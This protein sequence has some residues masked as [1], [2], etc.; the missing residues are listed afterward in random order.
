MRRILLGIA[1]TTMLLGTSNAW[2]EDAAAV[3]RRIVSLNLCA[4]ELVSRLA[5]RAS[6]ASVTWLSRDP[7]SSNVSDL[8]AQVPINHGLAEEI[9][10]LRRSQ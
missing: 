3:P 9:I 1:A 10:P 8:A 2:A 5:D 6:V 4:D 7:T